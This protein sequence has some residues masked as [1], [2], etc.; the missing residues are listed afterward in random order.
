MQHA[1]T[2][3][4]HWMLTGLCLVLAACGGGGGGGNGGVTAGIDRGGIITAT[5]TITGFGSVHVNGV[6]Y[7]T[8]SSTTYTL[9][10]NPGSESD[11]R[12]GQVVRVEGTI[13]TDGVTGTAT[14]IVFDDEV[15][16]PVQSI[17]LAGASLV[18]LGRTVTVSARTS[19][20]DRIS[21]RSLEGLTVGDRVEVSGLVATSGVVDATR[22]ERKTAAGDFEVKGTVAGLDTGQKRFTLG[23]QVVSYAT[24][25][26]T[27]FASGQPAAGDRV[28]VFGSLDGSGALVATRVEKDDGGAAGGADERGDY[29]GLITN[30]VSATDFAVAG[31]RITTTAST[32]YEGGTAANL[33]ADVAVEVEGRFNASG[34]IVATKVQFRRDAD[35][36]FAGRVD[37][38]NTAGNSLVVFG[39]TV[40][41]NS[42]TRFEDQSSA[43]VERF[44]LA[45]LAVGDYV[46]IDAYNDGSGLLATKIERDDIQGEVQVEGVAQN[47]AAPNLTVG[48][49]AVTTDGA[50]E[51]R[52][53]NSVTISSAAFFAAAP[54]RAVKVR[55]SLVGNTVLASRAEL[56]N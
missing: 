48:G 7:V 52:D 47:V 5:G 50:T 46:E 23:L 53:T 15:E 9:D 11:L 20:D 54:G 28:E 55:G 31:Q 43:N 6:R 49:V 4:S 22:I 3:K 12:V 19:F 35:T 8:G 42:L 25:Q 17:D 51:F 33:A 10:D 30:F 34:V 41:V 36:E 56:E 2:A 24:A 37:S 32:S 40:R 21:P 14:R 26:L 29:E 13:E 16:G 18:V 39:V 27:G 44:S 1:R 45:N 38:I